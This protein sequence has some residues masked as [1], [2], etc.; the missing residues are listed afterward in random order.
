MKK[1]Y[2][3]LPERRQERTSKKEM[4]H[5][6]KYVEWQEHFKLGKKENVQR[7]ECENF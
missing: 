5:H 2:S 1:K 3:A 7:N 6:F 4:T